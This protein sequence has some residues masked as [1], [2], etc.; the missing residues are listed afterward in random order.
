MRPQV[1]FLMSS[2]MAVCQLVN[3]HPNI[4]KNIRC[5]ILSIKHRLAAGLYAPESPRVALG[6][7]IASPYKV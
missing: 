4:S 3:Y 1:G 2:I 6:F 7:I 5:N